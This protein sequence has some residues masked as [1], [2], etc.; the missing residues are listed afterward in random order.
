MTITSYT[1][2]DPFS[3]HNNQVRAGHGK[4]LYRESSFRST[5]IKVIR[6][7]VIVYFLPPWLLIPSVKELQPINTKTIST[8]SRQLQCQRFKHH[9]V[10]AH[11]KPSVLKNAESEQ[12]PTLKPQ[13]NQAHTSFI[14]IAIARGTLDPH[15]GGER[16]QCQRSWE[17]QILKTD[18]KLRSITA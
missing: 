10:M 2:V 4:V 11:Y 16:W 7:P 8:E 6:T 9:T 3:K 17:A 5:G 18:R 14:G 15:V 12:Q 13:K 1:K